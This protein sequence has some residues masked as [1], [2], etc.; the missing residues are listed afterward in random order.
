MPTTME[1]YHETVLS[2]PLD[3]QRRLAAMILEGLAQSD[4]A[5]GDRI[6]LA[7][8]IETLPPGPRCFPTW[9]EYERALQAERD[10]WDR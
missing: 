4:P 10:S 2:L 8:F 9:E 7:D 1:V 5:A 6:H 3:D